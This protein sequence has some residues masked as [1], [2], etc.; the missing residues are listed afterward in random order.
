MNLM[1]KHMAAKKPKIPAQPGAPLP[2]HF[3]PK[4][5]ANGIL[6]RPDGRIGSVADCV[7]GTVWITLGGL[8]MEM[9]P[10][11]AQTFAE[12]LLKAIECA[13]PHAK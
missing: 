5:T 1:E 6:M 11:A 13:T 8:A 3:H 4:D 7:R 10:A 12:H 9:T 2:P